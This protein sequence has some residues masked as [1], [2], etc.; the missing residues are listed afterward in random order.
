MWS[1]WPPGSITPQIFSKTLSEISWLK[2][3]HSEKFLWKS[4]STVSWNSVSSHVRANHANKI[5]RSFLN[6]SKYLSNTHLT[7]TET[8]RLCHFNRERVHNF[9]TTVVRNYQ[10]RDGKF[11]SSPEKMHWKAKLVFDWYA[12][13]SLDL[14]SGPIDTGIR[15]CW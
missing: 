11:K 10:R 2:E 15:L 9:Y 13:C 14:S 8:R 4:Q 1:A 7:T 6:V 12:D 3:W 5:I